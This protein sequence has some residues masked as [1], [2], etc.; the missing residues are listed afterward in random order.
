MAAVIAPTGFTTYVDGV[1]TATGSWSGTP[2][3]LDATHKLTLGGTFNAGATLPK[4]YAG[5]MDEVA[6]YNTALSA[7]AIQAHATAAGF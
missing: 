7:S 5:S 4:R 2:L 3:L 1:Q 6:L